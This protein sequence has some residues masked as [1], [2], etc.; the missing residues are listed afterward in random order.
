MKDYKNSSIY[1]FFKILIIGI[2]NLLNHVNFLT[3]HEIVVGLQL[4]KSMYVIN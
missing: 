1:Q 2:I 4:S 3:S